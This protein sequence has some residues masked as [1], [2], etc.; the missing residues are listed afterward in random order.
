[1]LTVNFPNRKLTRG[2]FKGTTYVRYLLLSECKLN[3]IEMNAFHDEPFRLLKNISFQLMPQLEFKV[4]ALNGLPELKCLIL[5]HGQLS[6]ISYRL[7][8]PIGETL[9]IATF[10][11]I[12]T[13]INAYDLFGGVKLL[14]LNT[15]RYSGSD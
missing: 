5:M 3:T 1:M 6:K 8:E 11:N 14:Q 2:W 7:L 4:G 9:R 12:G 10:N 15:I 13:A